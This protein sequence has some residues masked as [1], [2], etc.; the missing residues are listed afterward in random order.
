MQRLAVVGAGIGG[1]SAAY[2]AKK[3]LP[4][5][6]V[7]VYE[8]QD[9]IGGRIFT[10]NL[11]GVKLEV[12]ATF[13]NQANKTIRSLVASEGLKVKR[14][15]EKLDFAVWDGSKFVFKSNS[16]T[17]FTGFELLAKYKLS[18]ARVFLLLREAR[19]QFAH[20]QLGEEKAPGELCLLF[21]KAGLDKWYKK[22]LNELLCEAD[23]DPGF[24]NEVVEPITRSIYS[25]NADLGGL[26]GVASLIGVYSGS[27]YSL[28][29]GNSVLPV[30]LAET[31]QATIKLGQK[32]ESVEKISDNSYRIQAGKETAIFDYV[33]MAVPLELADITFCGFSM[34]Q[35]DHNH[36]R[37]VYRRAMRGIFNPSYF[38]L[39]KSAEP[40]AIV[41][42]TK[43]TGPVTQY[44]IQKIGGDE[45]LV[46]VSSTEPLQDHAFEGIFKHGGT[47]ILD[48]HWKAAYP[49]FKSIA[50]LPP[51][52]LDK[53]LIYLNAVEPAISSMETA[54]F[55][56]L[57]AVRIIA[58]ELG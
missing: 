50:K 34:L 33:I 13:Y 29:E 53:R 23:V 40:P 16:H 27:I 47:V 56:A 21:E 11:A 43:K 6:K 41:L 51:T 38:S 18:I 55:S 31:S 52:L 7:T 1:C 26:A 45:S 3:Y 35:S 37:S 28:A 17:L 24:I 48:H 8:T 36:Y 12:G 32:V 44:S 19:N 2:F 20:L 9:K 46:T 30:H 5:A 54:A 57:N 15:E 22:P 4:D 42:T 58:S 10:R 14:M 49:V 39:E 25:Q